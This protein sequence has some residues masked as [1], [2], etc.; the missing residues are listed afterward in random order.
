MG[1]VFRRKATQ[2]LKQTCFTTTFKVVGMAQ[3]QNRLSSLPERERRFYAEFARKKLA[4]ALNQA[5]PGVEIR[6]GIIAADPNSD[7]SETPLAL[8][9]EFPR[10]AAM[11]CWI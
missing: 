2:A 11:K 8:I 6:V 9:C 10:A 7:S 1:P 3:V 4:G 5:H